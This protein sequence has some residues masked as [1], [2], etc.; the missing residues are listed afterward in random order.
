MPTKYEEADFI[1]LQGPVEVVDGELALRIPLAAGGD[2]LVGLTKGAGKVDGEY[3]VIVL[4]PKIAELLGVVEGSLITV[5]N[6]NG[7]FNVRASVPK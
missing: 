2:R 7:E 4:Y 5:D 6:R 1:S 3:L